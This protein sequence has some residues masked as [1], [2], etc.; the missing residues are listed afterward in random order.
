MSGRRSSGNWNNVFKEHHLSRHCRDHLTGILLEQL[1]P[2]PLTITKNMAAKYHISR[3]SRN[4]I[5]AIMAKSFGTSK[6]IGLRKSFEHKISL[7][8]SKFRKK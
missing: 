2:I 5:N 8:K 3:K 1:G 6:G 4:N 7:L